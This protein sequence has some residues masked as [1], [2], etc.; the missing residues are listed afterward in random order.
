VAITSMRFNPFTGRYQH[1]LIPE[2]MMRYVDPNQ[3]VNGAEVHNV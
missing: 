2:Q 3:M 1:D